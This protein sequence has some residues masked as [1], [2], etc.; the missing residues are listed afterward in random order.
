MNTLMF[1]NVMKTLVQSCG[2]M[3]GLGE[4]VSLREEMAAACYQDDRARLSGEIGWKADSPCHCQTT[5]SVTKSLE[6]LVRELLN[7]FNADA[8]V[9]P[10]VM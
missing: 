1:V 10:K 7:H 2:R 5:S 9:K 3:R 6:I 8:G 4:P